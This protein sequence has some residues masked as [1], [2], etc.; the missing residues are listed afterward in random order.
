M[1][2]PSSR[3][4]ANAHRRQKAGSV[5]IKDVPPYTFVGGVPARPIGEVKHPIGIVGDPEKFSATLVP[6]KLTKKRK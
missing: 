3:T 4:K 6:F 1:K 2:G 5:V